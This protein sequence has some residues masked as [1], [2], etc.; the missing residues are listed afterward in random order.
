M[1]LLFLCHGAVSS[2][3]V[4]MLLAMA[5]VLNPAAALTG[6]RSLTSVLDSWFPLLDSD[7]SSPEDET[8]GTN[9]N[10]NQGSSSAVGFIV[11]ATS[12]EAT[13][14]TGREIAVDVLLN[15]SGVVPNDDNNADDSATTTPIT[16]YLALTEIVSN[17]EHGTCTIESNKQESTSTSAH[18]LRYTPDDTGYSGF[19][20]CG[21]KACIEE[22]DASEAE[23]CD[24][25]TLFITITKQAEEADIIVASHPVDDDIA[26]ADEDD[27]L[28]MTDSETLLTE[29][30]WDEVYETTYPIESANNNGGGEYW[31]NFDGT[32][33]NE[34][35]TLLTIE[36]QTDKHGDDVSW[37]LFSMTS[38]STGV[39]KKKALK[40][41]GSYD[42]YSHDII[43]TCLAS[44]AKYAFTIHD[45]YGDGL[46]DHARGICGYY[47][48]Y[49]NG[50]EIVHVTHYGYN[51]TNAINVGYDPTPS[52]TTRHMG[53]L[54]AHNTRRRE[55]HERYNTSYVPLK[56]SPRLA[57]ESM[58]WAVKL[59]DDCEV[60]GVEHEPGVAEGENL[61]KN[62][63][64]EYE[65][66]TAS[67]GQLYPPESE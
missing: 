67:W 14:Y 65:N 64:L 47:K 1:K 34:D 62:L 46:C 29:E 5:T 20:K 25:A 53:Y 48:L 15:D 55:W 18:I 51:N 19:D 41:G 43:D 22:N 30:V 66:G 60:P 33:C 27:F 37:E 10:G 9:N 8:G 11:R 32:E 61:A 59:L 12:D 35:E 44:P 23:N 6:S 24:Y 38:I 28:P 50:R 58:R 52:M 36:V 13:T 54:E 56:W 63:G 49:L 39:V 40:S 42:S 57:E 17:G 16:I 2:P 3:S 21:Y 26:G 4:L 7:I 45:A 31:T